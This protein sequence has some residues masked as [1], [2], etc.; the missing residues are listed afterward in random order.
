MLGER[1][2]PVIQRMHTDIAGKITGMLLEIWKGWL[3]H[4]DIKEFYVFEI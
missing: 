4:S 1:L 3:S 2:L